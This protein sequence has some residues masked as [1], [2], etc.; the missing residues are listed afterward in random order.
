[1]E[2]NPVEA[3]IIASFQSIAAVPPTVAAAKALS[4]FGE[5]ALGWIGLGL[6]G[7]VVDRD[8]AWTW[9]A[10]AVAAFVAHGAAVV[11]KRLVRRERPHAGEVSVLANTPSQLSFPSAHAAS[12]T[13]AAVVFGS[14][15]PT[16]A[17][18]STSAMASARVLLGVHY[19]SDVLAG[20]AIGGVVGV[21]TRIAHRSPRR[22][23]E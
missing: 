12:T 21:A 13:A 1:M 6:V 22:G 11:V 7:A 20:T 18:L 14:R 9:R 23:R 4:I 10:T 17:V 19:P 8:R 16:V 5:H 2:W 3:R 15:Y